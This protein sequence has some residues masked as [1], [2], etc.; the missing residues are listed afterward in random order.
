MRRPRRG[1]RAIVGARNEGRSQDN[2]SKDDPGSYEHTRRSGEVAR[3]PRELG[4]STRNAAKEQADE[5][6]GD[7]ER[8]RGDGRYDEE[9][10]CGAQPSDERRERHQDESRE[11]V[12]VVARGLEARQSENEPRVHDRELR[13][14][15]CE[16]EPDGHGTS[17]GDGS[18]DLDGSELQGRDAVRVRSHPRT[19]ASRARDRRRAARPGTRGGRRN[20]RSDIEKTCSAISASRAFGAQ[21]VVDLRRHA[22]GINV[23]RDVAACRGRVGITQRYDGSLSDEDHRVSRRLFDVRRPFLGVVH[24]AFE[25]STCR[26]RA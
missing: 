6:H 12:R 7:A 8:Q 13:D 23:H 19:S 17:H 1:E 3:E 4:L 14:A 21:R 10:Q 16:P 26:A 18:D 25:R 9:R 5:A 2:R 22:C 11:P 20:T 24:H 15:M